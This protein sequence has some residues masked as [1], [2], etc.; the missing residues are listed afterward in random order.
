MT[1]H[2]IEKVTFTS[3]SGS[4]MSGELAMPHGQSTAPAI[5]LIQEWW[6]LNPNIRTYLDRLAHAGFIAI[7]P[8]LYHG[9]STTDAEE[10]AHLMGQ[11]N[12]AKALDEIS[13][14]AAYVHA[15][16]RS[17]GKV[18]VM[19]FCLGGALTFAAAATD[20]IFSAAVPFYGIPPEAAKIDLS[21]ISAPVLAHFASRDQWATADGARVIQ[22]QLKES[23]RSMELHVYEA[24]HAFMNEQR[25]EVHDPEASKA[26]WGRTV[27]FLHRH[28]G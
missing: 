14:A 1:H 11:L 12:W 22:E 16:A 9:V 18:G 13:G 28:L 8:D 5:V 15:H 7:A 23:G 27:E 2:S 6:G 10:A 19:G 21:K 17:S 24:D 25:P 3:K 26:A 20:S 4:A